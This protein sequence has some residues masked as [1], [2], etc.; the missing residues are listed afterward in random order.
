MTIAPAGAK[1]ISLPTQSTYQNRVADYWNAEENPVNL[2]LG[3]IDDLYHHHY[4]I[5]DA[6]RS[7]LDEPDPVR[8]Q[9]RLTAE[10]HRLE[11][12]Q[13]E[14]L[15]SRLGPLTPDD[16]V[17]DAGCGR[18]GGSIVANLRHGC[19]ADGVTIS[20]KQAAFANEQAR[21]RGV[22]DKVR[23]H[24]RNMLDTG[25]AT[26]GYAASWNNESTMYVELD[27]LFAEHARLLRRGGRYVVIT[28]CYNDTYGRASREVSLINAHYICDIHP[29]S[30]YFRAMARNRLVPVHVEDLTATALP[31]W[32]LRQE[33][34]H[35]VTGIEETFLDAYRNGSFQYL[36]IVADRV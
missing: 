22:D 36:L 20:A 7:V 4:G 24:H 28:G 5:G 14:L 32:E 29:R 6:D 8:R 18:G 13:A 3:K 10:L 34:E 11:H 33:A 21:A 16:R 25:F 26:G 12:A 2:E 1:G 27:L 9:E 17:F 30:E 15:A 19:H 31:Y 23:Y 35:L